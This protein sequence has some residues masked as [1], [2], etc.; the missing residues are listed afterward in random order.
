MVWRYY[1]EFF[2]LF[3]VNKVKIINNIVYEYRKNIFG[4]SYT[5]RKKSIDSTWITDLMI[6]TLD[7]FN[8]KISKELN[9]FVVKQCLINYQRVFFWG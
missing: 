5:A 6:D 9:E 8:I 4:I 2:S 3:K 1:Y 7:H